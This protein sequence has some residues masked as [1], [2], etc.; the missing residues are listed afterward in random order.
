MKL[1]HKIKI[2][3][4]F[5]QVFSGILIMLLSMAA[6]LLTIPML[7]AWLL[8]KLNFPYPSF[9]FPIGF[10]LDALIY[11]AILETKRRMVDRKEY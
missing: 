9:G 10:I 11:A 4:V 6:T 5:F 2:L 7:C 3:L 8:T 1:S